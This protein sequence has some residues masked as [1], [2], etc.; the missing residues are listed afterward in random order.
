MLELLVLYTTRF[1]LS[2]EV[3]RLNA[4]LSPQCLFEPTLLTWSAIDGH[5]SS[6]LSCLSMLELVANRSP[7]SS[8][9]CPSI[10]SPPGSP[11]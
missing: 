9:I 10:A 3:G 5:K 1:P 2:Q 7:K 4:G 11:Y 8:N 6:R